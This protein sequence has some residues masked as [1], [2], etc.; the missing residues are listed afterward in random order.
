MIRAMC[1]LLL[2]QLA[3]EMLVRLTAIPVPG[4]VAGMVLLLGAFVWRGGAPDDLRAASRGLLLNLSLLFVPAGV[5]I[6]IH[7]DRV[8]LE[9]PILAGALFVSTLVTALVTALTFRAVQ[10]WTDRARPESRR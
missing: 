5:G 4:P 2:C 3:G 7:L 10:R 8:R 1:I 9:W 6:M